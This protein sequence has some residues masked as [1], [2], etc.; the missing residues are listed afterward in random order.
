MENFEPV[1]ISTVP[2]HKEIQFLDDMIYEHNVAEIKR[3]DGKLFSKLIYDSREN[4]VAGITGWT[5][6]RACEITLF[7][8]KHDHRNKGYGKRLLDAAE[9]EAR[10]EKCKTM[11]LR[12]YSFQAPIFYLKRGYQVEHEIKDFPHGHSSFC[13]IK[14]LEEQGRSKLYHQH[15]SS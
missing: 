10:N 15:K 7:W 5:W 12:T 13:L 2:T 9:T 8:V 4:I 14:R 11:F 1:I 3:D 6:A